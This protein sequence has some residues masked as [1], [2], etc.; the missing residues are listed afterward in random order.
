[1]AY[2]LRFVLF[3]YY[4]RSQAKNNIGLKYSMKKRD[5]LSYLRSTST[6]SFLLLPVV[7][8]KCMNTYSVHFDFARQ[9]HIVAHECEMIVLFF[10]ASN[11]L[12]K[13]KDQC[14]VSLPPPPFILCNDGK[15]CTPGDWCAG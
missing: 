9:N 12:Q 2:D 8:Y 13:N 1:M 6:K 3:F 5:V 4:C 7:L 10:P 14:S 11:Q 15:N